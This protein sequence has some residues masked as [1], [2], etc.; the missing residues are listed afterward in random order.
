MTVFIVME[1]L[2]TDVLLGINALQQ[3]NA[4]IHF[5]KGGLLIDNKKINCIFKKPADFENEY[6][7]LFNIVGTHKIHFKQI[8]TLKLRES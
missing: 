1:I 3:V 7:A 8:Y 6:K 5:T 4:V 2:P